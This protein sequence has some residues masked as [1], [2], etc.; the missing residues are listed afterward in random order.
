[1]DIWTA[2]PTQDKS[3][4]FK[5]SNWNGTTGEA[6][7]YQYSATNA[8]ILPSTNP[9][10]WISIDIPMSNFQCINTP[11]GNAC[12]SKNDFVQFVITSDL[13]TVYYDNLYLHK[14]TLGVSSF[15]T[16]KIKMYPNPATT[17]FTID[18][19]EAVEKVAVYNMLG[20]EV[21]AQ[22]TNSQQVT[23]DISTLQVGVY[24]VKATIN[25]VVSTSRIIKE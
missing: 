6:N 9:G 7:A 3:F 23:M 14:N 13:G 15:E 4:N 25:G 12:P 5:F 17:N 11:P 20:Q 21:I 24:V 22:N 8:N 1:M 19:Q 16:S 10:T 18:A 2:T